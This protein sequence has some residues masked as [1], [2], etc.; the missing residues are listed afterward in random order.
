MN[1]LQF[2]ALNLLSLVLAV[3]LLGHYFLAQ[4][5]DQLGQALA[6]DQATLNSARQQIQPLFGQLTG[7]IAQGAQSD[8]QLRN[9]LI[10]YGLGVAAE[11]DSKQQKLP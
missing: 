2:W 11:T 1:K 10:K 4:R 7:R 5:N 9:L 8:P 6:R 3:L